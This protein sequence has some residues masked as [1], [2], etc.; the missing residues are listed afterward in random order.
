MAPSGYSVDDRVVGRRVG[1]R[2]WGCGL[3]PGHKVHA[4]KGAWARVLPRKGAPC[5]FAPALSAR[6]LYVSLLITLAIAS[7][8]VVT[9]ASHGVIDTTFSGDGKVTF[10]FERDDRA[11][12]VVVQPDGKI[13]VAGAIDAGAF[14]A[15]V[16]F[17]ADGT[18]DTTFGGGDAEVALGYGGV[19]AVQAV[20]L[21]TD[22]KIVLAGIRWP[23]PNPSVTSGNF[24]VIRLTADGKLDP[25]FGNSGRVLIDFGF[26][27]HATGVAI[28]DDGRIIVAGYTDFPGGGGF[29]AI[30]DF[31]VARLTGARRGRCTFGSGGR[32]TVGFVAGAKDYANA[33]AIDGAGRIVLA[34]SSAN[35]TWPWP[36]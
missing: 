19:D 14:F 33:V 21:Q 36:V 20:A 7:A 27:D 8:H 17:N 2:A 11:R 9:G 29:P 34:G 32:A 13:V 30:T 5:A 24:V 12:A 25:D 26:D 10:D 22:G 15:V 31:A 1:L 3:A 28:Q 35:M 23:S 16:R 6:V 4:V 18:P